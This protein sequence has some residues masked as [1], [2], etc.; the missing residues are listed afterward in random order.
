MTFFSVLLMSI[1][2]YLTTGFLFAIPFLIKGVTSI[3]EGA[4]GSSWGFR[5][6]IIPG[7]IVFWPFLLRKWIRANKMKKS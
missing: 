2:L 5:V 4:H 3:D 6:I 7:T 1:A